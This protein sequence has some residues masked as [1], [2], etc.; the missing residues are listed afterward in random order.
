M[1]FWL[2]NLASLK[3]YSVNNLK[4]ALHDL[5]LNNVEKLVQLTELN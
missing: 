2:F 4:Y 5:I 1:C 3:K